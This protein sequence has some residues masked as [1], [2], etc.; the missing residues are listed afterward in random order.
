MIETE[1]K[2]V[3]SA[4]LARQARKDF[5]RY[6]DGWASIRVTADE[7]MKAIS[8]EGPWPSAERTARE[9]VNQERPCIHEDVLTQYINK[10]V[11]GAEAN[12]IGITVQPEGPGTDPTTAQFEEN[13]IR[14]IDYESNA[15]QAR[16]CAL[17]NSVTQGYGVWEIGTDWLDP[18][19]GDEQK[20][21]TIAA[22]DPWKYLVDPDCKKP[23]WSDMQGAF[24]LVRMSHDE[25]RELFG[26]KAEIKDFQG[27]MTTD[28][29]TWVDEKT[30][31]VA[32]W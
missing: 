9:T 20:I 10:V 28:Y 21:V 17:E 8:K 1:T 27:F 31:Q 29:K 26:D 13:R 6:T 19:D 14:Q 22:M 5:D 18:E 3:K 30:V 32:E 24:K 4:D 15:V 23:D 11:N 12:P 7:C 25:F 16:L 2:P